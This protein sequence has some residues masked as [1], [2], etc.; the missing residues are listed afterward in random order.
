MDPWPPRVTCGSRYCLGHAGALKQPPQTAT[1]GKP[2][3]FRAEISMSRSATLRA[4][5]KSNYKLCELCVAIAKSPRGEAG[6]LG[7]AASRSVD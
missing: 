7:V 4:R 2:P 5:A 6:V 3:K 1:P